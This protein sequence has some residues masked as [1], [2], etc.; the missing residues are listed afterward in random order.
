MRRV[1]S[2]NTLG[3]PEVNLAKKQNDQNIHEEIVPK[4]LEENQEDDSEDSEAISNISRDGG[5]KYVREDGNKSQTNN[6]ENPDRLIF[7]YDTQEE[8][9]SSSSKNSADD[10][11]DLAFA[12]EE[13][14]E[15][16]L[17]VKSN[18]EANQESS[19]SSRAE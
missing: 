1:A 5:S 15:K 17:F 19:E 13:Q 11:I 16:E 7:K 10:Q 8:G 14:Q 18:F 6:S 12:D 9:D 4:L 3:F 2:Q